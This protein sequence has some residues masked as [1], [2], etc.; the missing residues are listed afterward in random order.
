MDELKFQRQIAHKL[1]GVKGQQQLAAAKV[2]VVGAGGLGCPALMYL[3][4]A[5]VGQL[6]IVDGDVVSISNLPRQVLYTEAHVG[7]MKAAAAKQQLEK[8]EEQ[9]VISSFPFFLDKNNALELIKEW[10]VVVDCTDD[11]AARY[12]LNDACLLLNKP[13]V[14]GAISRDEGQVAVF[15]MEING[16]PSANYRDLF[17]HPTS[18]DE[19]PNCEETGVIG[20]LPGTIGILQAN[21]VIKVIT[22]PSSLLANKLFVLNLSNYS[23]ST[24]D[25]DKKE[26]YAGP[27]TPEAFERFDYVAYC[28]PKTDSEVEL[29]FIEFEKM[30]HRPDVRIVDVRER[31]EPMEQ[32]IENAIHLPFS[33][34]EK[35]LASLSPEVIHVFICQSGMRSHKAAQRFLQ[36]HPSAKAFSLTKGMKMYQP[37][38]AL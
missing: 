7:C 32:R 24:F 15:N 2:L 19:I 29:D 20:V 31:N 4:A 22:H 9:I 5:G 33:D 10:D 36:L 6:G 35:E 1:I 26:G 14:Y 11:F 17:P 3:A 30:L 8:R 27:S 12:M 34:L 23:A 25:I 28:G 13:W 37:Q 18:V 38:V 21:E 16:A